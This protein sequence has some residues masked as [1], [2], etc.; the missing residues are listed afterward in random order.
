[1]R[2]IILTILLCSYSHIYAL[3]IGDELPWIV[4]NDV[5]A[6]GPFTDKQIALEAFRGAPLFL[7]VWR[8]HGGL[9]QMQQNRIFEIQQKFADKG[10]LLFSICTNRPKAEKFFAKVE[11]RTP[12]LFLSEEEIKVFEPLSHDFRFLMVDG[13]GRVVS[14]GNENM[15]NKGIPRTFDGVTPHGR[16]IVA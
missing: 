8:D 13:H 3:A 16:W 12:L 15:H 6:W 14:D 11:Q 5:E 2:L 10:L 1:M 9:K 4:S 7:I